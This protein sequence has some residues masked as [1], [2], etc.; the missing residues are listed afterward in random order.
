MNGMNGT[1][2]MSDLDADRRIADW[3]ETG[4]TTLPDATNRAIRV[5]VHSTP[6]KRSDNAPRRYLSMPAFKIALG[7]TVIGVLLLGG[8]LAFRQPNLNAPGASMAPCA[9]P[10]V[11]PSSTPA[12][13]ASPAPS[14]VDTSTWVPFTSNRYG[15]SMC[16]PSDWTTR[17]GTDPNPVGTTG[18]F[19][20][21]TNDEFDTSGSVAFTVTSAPAPTGTEADFLAAYGTHGRSQGW[22]IHCWPVTEQEWESVVVD[23]RPAHVHG[24]YSDCN[25]TEALAF[26]GGRL[27]SLGASPNA[28]DHPFDRALF[29]AFLSTVT[30]DPAAAD[31]SPA[32][33]PAASPGASPN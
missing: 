25:F 9:V 10:P 16:L 5:A 20:Q 8:S 21:P 14:P 19:G 30:F 6:R 31:D 2:G 33:S 28:F 27:Y 22:P 12:S 23:G 1:Q 15:Y 3:L 32:A 18:D 26:V 13:G 17:R 11:P 29:D 4:P 7:A 24:G